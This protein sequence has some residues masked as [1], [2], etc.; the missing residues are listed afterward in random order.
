[1]LA[2]Q[3]VDKT[4]SIRN[5]TKSTQYTG[6]PQM[7]DSS[8]ILCSRTVSW[9]RPTDYQDILDF[10]FDNHDIISKKLNKKLQQAEL[11]QLCYQVMVV[12]NAKWLLNNTSNQY[13]IQ[14][15]L[16]SQASF[17]NISILY[18]IQILL[19]MPIS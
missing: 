8:L 13:L 18:P 15:K 4:S 17:A 12:K 14:H 6:F 2:L 7:I 19:F 16:Q 10:S 5:C 3:L 9:C 11:Q 1:M